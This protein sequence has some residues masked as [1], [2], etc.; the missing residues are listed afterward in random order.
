MKNSGSS[1]FP[2][3]PFGGSLLGRSHARSSR[4][5]QKGKRLHLILQ[6]TR[7]GCAA[8]K[9][10]SALKRARKVLNQQS[11]KH[12]ICRVEMTL[13]GQQLHILSD[14]KSRDRTIAWIRSIT[15]LLPRYLTGRH[16]GARGD[17]RT[18]WKFRPLT[19]CL[20]TKLEWTLRKVR[21]FLPRDERAN[22]V[23]VTRFWFLK[24]GLSG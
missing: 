2:L 17:R 14:I 22:V 1:H 5:L 15:G 23:Q 21:A 9:T 4:P 13:Q 6:L 19:H 16:K 8:L 3:H 12:L 18:F 20:D 11:R 24:W 10:S 7:F